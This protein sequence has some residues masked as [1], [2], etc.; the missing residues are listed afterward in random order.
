MSGIR[1]AAFSKYF[2]IGGLCAVVVCARH[3]AYLIAED[4]HHFQH[5]CERVS[6]YADE[7]TALE[8]YIA[9]N[10]LSIAKM[11]A[12]MDLVWPAAK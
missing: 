10:G 6:R 11:Q 12:S 2:A 4:S 8:E 3:G 1:V 7:A 5:T 9:S